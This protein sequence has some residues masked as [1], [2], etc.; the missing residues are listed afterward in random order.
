MNQGWITLIFFLSGLPVVFAGHPCNQ[1]R[2]ADVGW[3]DISASNAL[4]SELLSQAGY[5][6]KTVQLSLPVTFLSLKNRDVDVFLG[7]WMPSMQADIRPYSQEGSVETVGTLLKGAKFTLAVP[8]YVYQAGVHSIDQLSQFSDRFGRKIYGIEPGNDG[9]THIQSLIDDTAFQLKG[10]KL[11]AS[12]EQAMLAEVTRAIQRKQWIVFLGWEPHPMNHKISITYLKGASQYFGPNQGES[13]VFINTR[14]NY[15]KECPNIAN[16][17]KHFSLNMKI[18]T[19]LMEMIL[20][21]GMDPK[22]AAKTWLKEHPQDHQKWM[23]LVQP[24]LNTTGKS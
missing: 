12:S 17:L 14:K 16:F 19:N 22:T 23:Q 7:N 21:K 13:Q 4:A 20:D 6:T 24:A 11:V 1:V 3:T 2:M 10:W 15:L 5:E 9:N 18:E 8:Q